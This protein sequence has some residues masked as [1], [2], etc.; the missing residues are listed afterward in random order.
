[1]WANINLLVSQ[2]S[3]QLFFPNEN[4]IMSIEELLKLH[5]EI[6]TRCLEIMKKKNHDYTSGSTDPFVNFRMSEMI[7]IHPVLGALLRVMDKIKRIQTFVE[8]GK[9]EIANETVVDAIED[10]IN[11]FILIE[12][13][14]LESIDPES[15]LK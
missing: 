8:K 5:T 3:C 15:N 12:G 10:C 9:L 7:G 2:T 13:M 14:I 4:K 1:M 11:Y 6:S